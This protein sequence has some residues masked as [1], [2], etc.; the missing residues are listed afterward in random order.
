MKHL[1]NKGAVTIQ[2]LPQM[3]YHRNEFQHTTTRELLDELKETYGLKLDENEVDE[4]QGSLYNTVIQSWIPKAL[5]SLL[6][7]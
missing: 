2:S 7:A 4:W 5:L 3:L 1:F 6:C